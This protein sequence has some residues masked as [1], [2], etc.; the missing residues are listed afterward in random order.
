MTE[1]TD[2]TAAAT[3]ANEAPAAARQ[4]RRPRNR[5]GKGGGGGAQAQSQ[6]N[7]PGQPPQAQA[8]QKP[9]QAAPQRKVNPL[10]E[11]LFEL[12]PNLFGARFLP[13]K[14]G[15]FEDLAARHPDVLPRE[16]LKIAMGQHA[17]STRYLESVAAGL[18]RHDLDGKPVEPVAPEHVHHAIMEVFRRRQVRTKDDLRPQLHKR[19]I[20][21]IEASG[22]GREAYAARVRSRDAE[23]TAAL[24]DALAELGRQ[25]AK[26]EALMRAFEA[27]GKTETEFADMYGMEPKE[28]AT[29][30]ARARIDRQHALAAA[31]AA[32]AAEV[33]AQAAAEAEAEAEADVPS[34]EAATAEAP[35]ASPVDVTNA[36]AP[37]V[38][39]T[40]PDDTATA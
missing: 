31:E 33:A 12:Y 15:V 10:L 36:S 38:E 1:T 19:I 8:G 21:A 5:R 2:T 20:A 35:A 32:A 16:E 26:R 6:Q 3:D 18:Q 25:A 14:L 4:D 40:K 39:A 17:R 23:A 22:I 27:S 37:A 24:D 13:L 34:A 28:V 30:L 29:T 7:R 11:R 9:Q